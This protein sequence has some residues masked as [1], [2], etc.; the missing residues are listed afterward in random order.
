MPNHIHL[1]IHVHDDTGGMH[2]LSNQGRRTS[3]ALGNL[4][5]AYAKAINSAVKRTGSLFEHPFHRK[6]VLNDAYLARLIPYIHLNPQR[7]EFVDDFRAWP[8][9]SYSTL[10]EANST[11]LD[12]GRVMTAL[13][14][15]AIFEK[16]QLEL[17]RSEPVNP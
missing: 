12:Y 1:A 10:L 13:G 4:F 2:E 8:W 6:P 7:H 3:Q 17:A 15:A 16:V 9:S 5:N 14:G 11:W